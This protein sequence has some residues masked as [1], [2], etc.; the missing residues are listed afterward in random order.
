MEYCDLNKI[1]KQL[2]E[3]PIPSLPGHF[4]QN[5]LREIRHRKVATAPDGWFAEYFNVVF[6]PTFLSVCFAV[7]GIVGVALPITLRMTS[8]TADITA[9]ANNLG[10]YVFTASSPNLSSGLLSR[11][12]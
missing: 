4:A 2:A 12:P 5:V 11:L 10:L 6:R 9:T 1:L 3:A 8:N 7:T